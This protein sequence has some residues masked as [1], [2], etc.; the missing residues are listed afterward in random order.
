MKKILLIILISQILLA[1]ASISTQR[2]ETR[3]DLMKSWVGSSE[4]ELIQKWGTPDNSYTL[5]SGSKIISY[6]KFVH[7]GRY[8]EEKFMI[9]KGIVKKWGLSRCDLHFKNAKK[10]SKDIPIPQATL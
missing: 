7:P 4:E 3:N 6:E 1:C 2:Y 10:I 9:E 8:C 5:T